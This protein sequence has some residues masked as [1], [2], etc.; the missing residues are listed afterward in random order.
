MFHCVLLS[1][2]RVDGMFLVSGGHLQGFWPRIRWLRIPFGPAS[3]P[4]E[5]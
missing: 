2:S 3:C 4:G 1:Y 5:L